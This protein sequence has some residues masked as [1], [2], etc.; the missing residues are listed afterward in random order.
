LVAQLHGLVI[1]KP[2]AG[3]FLGWAKPMAGGGLAGFSFVVAKKTKDALP[4]RHRGRPIRQCLIVPLDVIAV[5]HGSRSPGILVRVSQDFGFGRQQEGSGKPVF[6]T[7]KWP[8]IW[9]SWYVWHFLIA[10]IV[11]ARFP[12]DYFFFRRMGGRGALQRRKGQTFENCQAGVYFGQAGH[13]LALQKGGRHG[14][15]VLGRGQGS[16]SQS[17]C[18]VLLFKVVHWSPLVVVVAG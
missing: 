17:L 2:A 18:Q 3:V 13:N 1:V 5:G 14:A 10:T 8:R 11:L 16:V 4:Q 15:W 6:Q 12:V 9:W 7:D